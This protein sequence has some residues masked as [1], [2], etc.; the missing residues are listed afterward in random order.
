MEECGKELGT[1]AWN[2]LTGPKAICLACADLDHLVFLP[3]G[4][5]ALTRRAKKNSRLSAAVLKWS[6]ASKRYERQ[7]L[8]VDEPALDQAEAE[9]FAVAEARRAKQIRA[10]GCLCRHS[11]IVR[12]QSVDLTTHS[13]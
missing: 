8:L 5:A 3:A 12:R 4:D 9:C 6:K 1:K 10:A 7:G 13:N 2:F 11:I